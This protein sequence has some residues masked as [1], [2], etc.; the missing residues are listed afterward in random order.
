LTFKKLKT[1]VYLTIIDIKKPTWL[2]KVGFLLQLFLLNDYY[3][4]SSLAINR[5]LAKEFGSTLGR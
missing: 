3:F 1:Y 5:T 4:S 2:P